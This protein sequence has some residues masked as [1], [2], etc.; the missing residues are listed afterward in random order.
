MRQTLPLGSMA[1]V[2]VR[3]HWSALGIAALIVVLL[4]TTVL[5]RAVP[6]YGQ[7]QYWLVA[8]ITGTLFMASLLIHEAAHALIARRRGLRVG[9][10]TLW[11]LGGYT[12]MEEEAKS[13]RVELATA[14]AG[15]LASLGIAAVTLLAYVFLPRPALA[16][17]AAG[18]LSTMNLL[19][20]LF[21]LL[22][23]A[24][25]DGGRVLHALLWWRFGDAA[26]ADRAAARA[27]QMLGTTL[28]SVGLASTFLW[29][30]LSGL[31]L[32]F[33]GWYIAMSARQELTVKIARAGLR[34]L[35]VA[36]VMTPVPDLAPAWMNVEKLIEGVVLHSRQTVFP[37][38]TLTGAAV[39]SVSLDTLAAVPPQRRGSTR[40]EA[41]TTTQRPVR[42][43]APDD[44]AALLLEQPAQ[45]QL[46]AVVVDDRRLV[47]M[48]TDADLRRALGQS[49]LRTGADV[50]T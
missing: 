32:A 37:V 7:A 5:P 30:W 48:V 31:W 44:E 29:N 9:S 49:L 38:V 42:T 35:R 40:V 45:G 43:L 22:P 46:I 21:N 3:A 17:S 23:G 24:P 15:P 33:L 12:E 10:V 1:G 4:G 13:P 36:E 50:T 6:G 16:A 27:G 28:I 8:A 47:G 41:L 11:V 2:P 20:G 39:G 14:A 34:G 18:W 25:L 26:R 19:L